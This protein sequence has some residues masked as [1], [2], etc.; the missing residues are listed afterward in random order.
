M[1]SI[2]LILCLS[3]IAPV[4]SQYV[5]L[6]YVEPNFSNGLY[7]AA[8]STDYSVAL[9][10]V[11]TSWFLEDTGVGYKICQDFTV[12]WCLSGHPNSYVELDDNPDA[13]TVWTW[14]NENSTNIIPIGWIGSYDSNFTAPYLD[15]N[16]DTI[17][18]KDDGDY[19]YNW[20]VILL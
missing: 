20:N 4:F 15:V 3:L 19:P 17:I 16:D 12:S 9:N 6:K 8:N 13:W 5:V 2:Y 7:I 14:R 11:E 18:I 1:K 10:P